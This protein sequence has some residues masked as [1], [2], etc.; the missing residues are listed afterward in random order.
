M[1]HVLNIARPDT[2][3]SF[4]DSH[5]M[6]KG[7]SIGGSFTGPNLDR[8]L[9]EEALTDLAGVLDEAGIGHG[10]EI[11]EYLASLRD[12]HKLCVSKVLPP[13]E[14]WSKVV[15]RFKDAFDVL[16][17][18]D[19]VSF[20]PKIHVARDH[21][22][23]FF[24]KTGETLYTADTSPTESTHSRLRKI[25]EK[26]GTRTVCNLGTDLHQARLTSG[27]TRQVWKNLP[28]NFPAYGEHRAEAGI[29]EIDVEQSVVDPPPEGVM[30][31][32][33]SENTATEVEA[34]GGDLAAGVATS[35]K[36]EAAEAVLAQFT[37]SQVGPA[38]TE[39]N[40]EDEA[41]AVLDTNEVVI[42]GFGVEVMKTFT[43]TAD[44]LSEH[45][46]C[47]HTSSVAVMS[48]L[49]HWNDI[50][51][52]RPKILSNLY[53][54]RAVTYAGPVE[55]EDN[56]ADWIM[57]TKHGLVGIRSC[58]NAEEFK[59]NNNNNNNYINNSSRWLKWLS[60]GLH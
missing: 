20:T 30:V 24:L 39:V 9:T 36:D 42:F 21:I 46:H 22:P 1:F 48:K 53:E 50:V 37:R 38:S 44:K 11:A 58:N 13:E 4:Y 47:A 18:L 31:D 23:E 28:L 7:R 60:V 51:M 6:P 40:T 45:Y 8:L 34:G 52:Y 14:E 2:M 17:K 56:L 55:D 29:D 35:Q 12:Y 25:E 15:K 16:K 3:K 26:H 59:V 54:D 33:V 57:N 41:D 27:V 10:V 32:L 5:G 43:K 49:G 19:F